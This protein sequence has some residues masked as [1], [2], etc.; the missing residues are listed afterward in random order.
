[1]ADED[2]VR[3]GW[4]WVSLSAISNGLSAE[5]LVD[6]LP[7]SHPGRIN[8]AIVVVDFDKVQP[9]PSLSDQLEALGRYLAEFRSELL[10]LRQAAKFE[11]RIG[12]LPRD[13]QEGLV[14][15]S[16]LLRS[17]AELDVDIMLDGYGS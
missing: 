11:L 17:L 4:A 16:Q 9:D 6:R 10:S 7:Q 2:E 8:S 15:P 13:P 5:D 14:V 12:W 3:E 1:L